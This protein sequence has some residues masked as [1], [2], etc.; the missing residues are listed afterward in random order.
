MIGHVLES[1][2]SVLVLENSEPAKEEGAAVAA[3]SVVAA[4]FVA[5]VE[6]GVLVTYNA[7]PIRERH[8]VNCRPPYQQK[9]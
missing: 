3:E 5:A 8:L 7:E 2:S 9:P 6:D 1:L 4:G